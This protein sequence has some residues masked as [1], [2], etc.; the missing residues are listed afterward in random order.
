VFRKTLWT[1]HT[2]RDS[3]TLDDPIAAFA[4]FK[5]DTAASAGHLRPYPVDPLAVY[6]PGPGTARP[7]VGHAR[8]LHDLIDPYAGPPALA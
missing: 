6:P 7:P 3:G 2:G 5:A 8:A 1:E 4:L